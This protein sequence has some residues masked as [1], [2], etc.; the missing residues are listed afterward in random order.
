MGAEAVDMGCKAIGVQLQFCSLHSGIF[1]LFL[2][3]GGIYVYAFWTQ[4]YNCDF[5][6]LCP[7]YCCHVLGTGVGTEGGRGCF[8]RALS[9]CTS[10]SNINCLLLLI[11]NMQKFG[12]YMIKYYFIPLLTPLHTSNLKGPFPPHIG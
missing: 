8:I 10:W 3:H 6:L 11:F 9:H 4:L 1:C 2:I 5:S 12:T 7:I